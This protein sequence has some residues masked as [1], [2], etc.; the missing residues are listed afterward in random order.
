[1]TSAKW[2]DATSA[3]RQAFRPADLI[4]NVNRVLNVNTSLERAVAAVGV[5]A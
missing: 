1:M 2:K 3:T 4:E 5:C